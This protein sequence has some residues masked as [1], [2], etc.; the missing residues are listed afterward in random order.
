MD[1]ANLRNYIG[2][3]Y[4]PS[5]YYNQLKQIVNKVFSDNSIIY[6]MLESAEGDA[7][8]VRKDLISERY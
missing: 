1:T 6:K 2:T 3:N 4:T 7:N 8:A 5:T